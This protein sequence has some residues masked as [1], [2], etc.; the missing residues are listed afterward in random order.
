MPQT[1]TAVRTPVQKA[2]L[3][4]SIVFALVGVAGFIPGLTT[5]YDTLQFA[6][7]ESQAMLLGVF[8]VSILHNIV[9]LAFGVVGFLMSRTAHGAYW[10]LVGGGIVYLLL[11]LYGL[12]ID[13]DSTANFV[14]LNTADN[15]LHL[16][17]GVGMAGLGLAL[18]RGA[19]T[20]RHRG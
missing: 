12:V 13:H 8:M 11:W 10:Y 6:G 15:W 5:G 7:H 16:L 19:R 4:V 9:H 14:P 17:L 2:A 20:T 18:G 3:A 1:G